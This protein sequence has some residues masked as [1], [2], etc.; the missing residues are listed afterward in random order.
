LQPFFVPVS[1]NIPRRASRSVVLGSTIMVQSR[2]L[3]AIR[4]DLAA[5]VSFPDTDEPSDL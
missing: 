4:T 2:P 5:K 1:N 3:T